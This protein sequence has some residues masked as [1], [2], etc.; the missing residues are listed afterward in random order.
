M[1]L[2][3]LTLEAALELAAEFPLAYITEL[4][5]VSFG[6]VPMELNP[7]EWVEAHFFDS[8]RELRFL[9]GDDG[10]VA[11]LLTE[12]AGD[13]FVDDNPIFDNHA[14]AGLPDVEKRVF[15]RKYI[16]SD[17]DGQAYISAVR[18]VGKENA[19]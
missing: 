18:F 9:P 13:R 19:E 16:Q 3:P 14:F 17:E 6:F 5:R 12:E 10:L 2:E 15:I 8:T 11:T 1:K 4:S 7:V